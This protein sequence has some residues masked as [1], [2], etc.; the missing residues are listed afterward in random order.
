MKAKKIKNITPE[1]ENE[2]L[3]NQLAQRE[4]EL[5]LISSVG[6]AISQQLKI[7]DIIKIIGD[8]IRDIFKSEVTEILLLDLSSNMITVPYSFYREYQT[9]EPFPLGEGLTSRII[10]TGKPLV[11]GTFKEA[12]KLGVLVQSEEEK[13]ETY[14]GVP[15]IVNNKVIGVVS[16][17]SYKKND[18][19]DEKV[20]LLSILSANMGIAL[21]NAKLFD[22]TKRLLIETE[23]RT[24]ELTIINS[25]G[26][27]MSKQLDVSTVT[28]IVGDKV[29]EIFNAEVTEILL[30]DHNTNIINVPYSYFKGYQTVDSFSLGSG[31]TS[32]VINSRKPLL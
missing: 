8:R 20:R 14:V 24:A 26:E 2:I 11:H 5:A 17:Q 10:Q 23:Q 16:I 22:E 25:V 7:E 31:L 28:K 1:Q 6:E 27:A 18:Y 4:A 32:K 21:T 3:K 15:I 29:R 13:T 12:L 19:S 30:L 9:A